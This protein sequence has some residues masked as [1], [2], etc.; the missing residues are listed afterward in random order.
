MGKLDH[1]EDGVGDMEQHGWQ[2]SPAVDRPYVVRECACTHNR[3]PV[4]ARMAEGVLTAAQPLG[5]E[6][7]LGIS[8]APG[9][10][11]GESTAR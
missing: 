1:Q 9:R 2:P 8:A 3:P 11:S 4:R 10:R 6:G 7:L 5:H